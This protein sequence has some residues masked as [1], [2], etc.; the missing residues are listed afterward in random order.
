MQPKLSVDMDMDEI[1]QREARND[2]SGAYIYHR[3]QLSSWVAYG[4]SAY[5]LWLIVREHGWHNSYRSYSRQFQVPFMIID[6]D[7]M[8]N[9]LSLPSIEQKAEEGYTRVQ[10][11]AT[12][13]MDAYARWTNKLCE[14]PNGGANDIVVD[15]P[16]IEFVPRDRFI[17]DSMNSFSRNF[18][19][20]T[21]LIIASCCL[22]VFSPLALF[23]WIAVRMEDGGP[24][25]YRQ[26]R[27]GRFG[28]PFNIL[29][30]RT[31]RI[32]SETSGPRLSAA[33]GEGD[34][35]LT[36]IGK[37]LRAHHL[38]E[39]PQLW[40]VFRGDM[41][42]IGPR[43]EREFFI[44]QIME[45]DARYVYLYQIRPGVTSYSTLY[46]GYTD[47]M[48]KMLRRLEYDLYYLGHRSLLLDMKILF[49]TFCHIVLGKRF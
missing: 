38:D 17:P 7:T 46:I 28:R 40:N 32:D 27:I 5:Y 49:K 34:P 31:M 39:L 6:S 24:A 25:I 47:T 21:D 10:M 12:I 48:E 35:R 43:P 30:F 41:A 2:G 19:R 29:K 37:F 3:K 11:D 8:N 36:K 9:I 23:C 44:N 15:T 33:G 14:T 4:L 45:Y 18:K 1:L 26:E 42:F 16:V 20:L 13:N 22:V